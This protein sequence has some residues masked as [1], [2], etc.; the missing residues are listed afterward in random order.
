MKNLWK[1]LLMV[2]ALVATTA[3]AQTGWGGVKAEKTAWGQVSG[4]GNSTFSTTSDGGGN[5]VPGAKCGTYS[6]EVVVQQNQCGQQLVCSIVAGAA[7]AAAG[8]VVGGGLAAGAITICTWIFQ[9]NIV[10]KTE[11]RQCDMNY[12]SQYQCVRGYCG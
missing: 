5:A 12:N 8:T 6:K 2:I 3:Q 11:Y 10:N 7:G 9:C 1:A 4:G